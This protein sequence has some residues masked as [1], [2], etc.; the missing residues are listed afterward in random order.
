[1]ASQEGRAVQGGPFG[2]DYYIYNLSG[3]NKE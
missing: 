1:M 2:M 3:G